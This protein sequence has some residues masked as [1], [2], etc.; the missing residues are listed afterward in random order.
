[1]STF[2]RSA[3]VYKVP[4]VELEFFLLFAS[5]ENV[6]FK[7]VACLRINKK[8]KYKHVHKKLFLAYKYEYSRLKSPLPENLFKK[9]IVEDI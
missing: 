3:R 1:M 9:K 8:L 7:Y 6:F 5:H 4:F 2:F